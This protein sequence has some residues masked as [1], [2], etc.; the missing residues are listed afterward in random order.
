M[1]YLG[2]RMAEVAVARA[3]LFLHAA[4]EAARRSR[5]RA[6]GRS[7]GAARRHNP[8]LHLATAVGD[9]TK[10]IAT[11]WL[12]GEFVAAARMILPSQDLAALLAD[13]AA[14]VA[15][16]LLSSGMAAARSRA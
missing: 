7:V 14:V 15:V 4:D 2:S 10:L 8:S 11:S 3:M 13:G 9:T 6:R 5:S 1:P 12:A 16:A